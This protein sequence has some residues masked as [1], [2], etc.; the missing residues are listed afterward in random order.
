VQQVVHRLQAPDHAELAL[1]DPTHVLAAQGAP[2]VDRGRTGP[3]PLLELLLLVACQGLLATAPGS[4]GQRVGA[5]GV[6][7]GDPGAHLALG[8]EHPLG[9][10]G[11]GVPEHGQSNG[12][13]PARDPRPWRG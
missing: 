13:Q 4:V 2:A 7:P 5:A 6:V 12:A 3:Q 11:R 9:H 10:I 8:Q 1:E